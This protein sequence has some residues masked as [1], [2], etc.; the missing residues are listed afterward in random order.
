MKNK[1]I[2]FLVSTLVLF[3]ASAT[4]TAQLQVEDNTKIKIGNRNASLHLSKTGR[5]G[6]ATSKTFGSGETGLIIEYGVSE[7]SGMYLDGQNITL[8]SP[9]DDQLIRVF[10]EDNMTEKAFMNN[11][12]TWVTSSDSIHKEEVEQIIS[13][14][15]KVKLIKGVSYHYKND[16][17]KE[18]D[19][20][21]QTNNKQRDFGFIA[22]ELE[23]VYPELVYTNE[24]G[25]KFINYNGLIPVLTAALNEQQ[26]EIDILKGEMEA[27]RKQVEALIKTNKKE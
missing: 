15:E 26:T 5:Y 14:L 9:G 10:D 18:N 17:T 1:T 11:L 3:L 23:K 4:M 27:L 6:E 8:W 22:Q 19:Y 13:A 16:S 20:K 25:H 2:I 7:S 21:K 24:F 12:G